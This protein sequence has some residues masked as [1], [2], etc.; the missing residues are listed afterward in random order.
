[1]SAEA[2]EAATAR[3]RAALEIGSGAAA[4]AVLGRLLGRGAKGTVIG[5]ALGAAAGT[6]LSVG[7]FRCAGRNLE[8]LPPGDGPPGSGPP[9]S[10]P[11]EGWTKARLYQR[12]KELEVPGR[13]RMSKAEL[14]EAVR[15]RGG[16]TA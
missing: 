2:R 7:L 8:G 6:V 13:S 12:A 11:P 15:R 16:E 9:G 10:G 14:L 5:A 3:K 1:M 4:G